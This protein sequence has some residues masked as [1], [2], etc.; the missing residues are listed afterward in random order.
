MSYLE[1]QLKIHLN[2]QDCGRQH[3]LEFQSH[4]ENFFKNLSM[5]AIQK[6]RC[7]LTGSLSSGEVL[8]LQFLSQGSG[9]ICLPFLV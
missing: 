4:Y 6:H 2:V 7:S 1:F 3:R 9:H 5:L 8:S